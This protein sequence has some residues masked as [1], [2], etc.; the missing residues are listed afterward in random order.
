MVKIPSMSPRKEKKR[1]LFHCPALTDGGAERVWALLARELAGRGHEVVMAVD[2]EAQNGPSLPAHIP[3][4]VLGG[5]HLASMRAL[6]RLLNGFAPHAA[7]SAIAA[8]PLKLTIAARGMDVALIHAFHGFEEWRTGRMSHLTWRLLPWI[9]RHARA[10]VAVS[11]ALRATLIRDWGAPEHKTTRIYNPV[12]LP[13]PLPQVTQDDLRARP[14]HVIAIG[15][16]SRE[17]GHGLLLRALSMM[18]THEARL[19]IIGE[20]PQRPHLEEQAKALGVNDRVTFA[21]WQADIWPWLGRARVLALPSRTESF[22]NVVVEALACGLPV[23]STDTPGPREILRG[24]PALGTLVPITGAGAM[25]RALDAALARPGTPAPRQTR[26]RD[27]SLSRGVDAWEH[28]I[29]S[30][31]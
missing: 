26:A 30:S 13:Q 2:S 29:L 8:S 28:L 22:G 27:F 31:S 21:G 18:D 14:P 20:G 3:V 25:A 11:D 4:Q 6:R 19:T 1:L 9:A 7:L 24:D 16:L 5:G 10:I 15:R 12:A 23:V 17:K